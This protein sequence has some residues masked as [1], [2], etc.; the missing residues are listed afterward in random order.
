MTTV[1]DGQL[2]N[3]QKLGILPKN[4]YRYSIDTKKDQIET[5]PLLRDQNQEPCEKMQ[6]KI[7]NFR[8][9]LLIFTGKSVSLIG[10]TIF[11]LRVTPL[12]IYLKR[13]LF[14]PMCM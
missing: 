9:F 11:H 12:K 4:K 10:L 8:I 6:A 2:V 3:F 7:A 13:L 1:F 14:L 5:Y